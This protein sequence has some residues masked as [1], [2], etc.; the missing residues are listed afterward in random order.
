MGAVA[1]I[2]RLLIGEPDVI[3]A[4]LL[5]DFPELSIIRLRRGGLPVRLGGWSLLQST[6]SAITLWNIVFLAPGTPPDAELLL[7]ELRHVQQF[8]SSRVFPF[9][10]LIESLTRGYHQN[11]YELDAVAFADARLA[12]HHRRTRIEES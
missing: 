2:R 12:A 6:A 11:R 8:Q 9:R 4:G 3:P 1:L 5:A 10:Y 7:H